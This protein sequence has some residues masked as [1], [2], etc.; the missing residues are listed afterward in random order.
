M[1]V[2]FLNF[3]STKEYM[4]QNF[5]F[6]VPINKGDHFNF[7]KILF[8]FMLFIFSFHVIERYYMGDCGRFIRDSD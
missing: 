2:I 4:M 3:F 5:L 6:L 7:K 1:I 8:Y